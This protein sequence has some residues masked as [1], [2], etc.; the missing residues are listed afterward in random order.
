MDYADLVRASRRLD[1][2]ADSQKVRIALLSDAA[3]QQFAPLLRV[4]F[5]SCGVDAS[6]YEGP[7]DGI[8]LEALDANS[9]LYR[10]QPDVI[11]LLNSVQALRT[12]FGK[13]INDAGEFLR[14]RSSEL[15]AV[16]DAIH[17]RASAT[18]LQS[19]FV[20]PYDRHFGNYDQRRPVRSHR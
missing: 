7:F 8:R 5:H 12:A 18:I 3:T 6:I 2:P 16:W 11:V 19:T 4:L 13:R 14:E 17:S 15:L 20:L 10:F 9:G 1:F